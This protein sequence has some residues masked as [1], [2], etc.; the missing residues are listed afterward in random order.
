MSPVL[1]VS[2]K[3]KSCWS[4]MWK[5]LSTYFTVVGTNHNQAVAMYAIDSLKQLS[6]KFLEKEELGGFQF[7]KAFLKPVEVIMMQ[8]VNPVIRELTLCVIQNMVIARYTNIASGWGAV[9]AVLGVAAG[10]SNV[11]LVQLGF[12]VVERIMA[13]YFVHVKARGAG[14][15]VGRNRSWNHTH[16]L[17]GRFHPLE[18]THPICSHDFQHA[19]ASENPP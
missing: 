4:N 19:F 15:G 1:V 5:E 17:G 7:Q 12:S 14:T 13:D 16:A 2:K 6:M 3:A 18:R 9:L 8:S 11:D 10:D